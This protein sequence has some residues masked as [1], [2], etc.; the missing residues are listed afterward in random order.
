MTSRPRRPPSVPARIGG[1]RSIGEVL[2]ELVEMRPDLGVVLPDTPLAPNLPRAVPKTHDA[3][4]RRTTTNEQMAIDMT[5]NEMLMRLRAAKR[6]LKRGLAVMPA[7]NAPLP[8]PRAGAELERCKGPVLDLVAYLGELE[9][10]TERLA[11][12]AGQGG[13]S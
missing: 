8:Y 13:D 2:R 10:E 7:T 6:F 12:V 5:T 4:P 3:A 9:R 11:D 1:W